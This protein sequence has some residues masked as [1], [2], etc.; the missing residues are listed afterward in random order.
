M[1]GDRI[2]QRL[3]VG[4]GDDEVDALDF[5]LDH[6]GDRIAARAAD[7]DDRDARTQFLYRGRS[8]VN[9]HSLLSSGR[10]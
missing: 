7:T 2:V 1:L 5:G 3:R 4:I 9:A 10:R 8:D 6:V